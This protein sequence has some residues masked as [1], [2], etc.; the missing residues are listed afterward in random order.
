MK[1]AIVGMLVV[2]ALTLGLASPGEGADFVR[3][4][5]RLDHKMSSDGRISAV[6]GLGNEYLVF[7]RAVIKGRGNHIWLTRARF[8]EWEQVWT[9]FRTAALAKIKVRVFYDTSARVTRFKILPNQPC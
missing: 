6:V 5:N 1:R 2:L 3:C 9:D 8:A 4:I 7:H